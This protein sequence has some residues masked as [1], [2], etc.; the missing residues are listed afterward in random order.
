MSS[1]NNDVDELNFNVQLMRS[2]IKR[3]VHEP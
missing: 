1:T 2:G 3:I